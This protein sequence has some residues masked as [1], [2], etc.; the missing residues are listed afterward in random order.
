MYKPKKDLKATKHY[1]YI[2][3]NPKYVWKCCIF[4]NSSQKG[5]FTISPSINVYGQ[6]VQTP[7][8]QEPY[9]KTVDL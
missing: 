2:M 1:N 6:D 9:W 7:V 3:E 8:T 5:L 4:D